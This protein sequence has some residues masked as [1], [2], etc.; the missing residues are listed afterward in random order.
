M[1]QLE[2]HSLSATL[3]QG[4]G[5]TASSLSLSWEIS[6]KNWNDWWGRSTYFGIKIE[7]V[8]KTTSGDK[9]YQIQNN[10]VPTIKKGDEYFLNPNNFYIQDGTNSKPTNIEGQGSKNDNDG[11][12]ICK[13]K[14]S[15]K[16]N[17]VNTSIYNILIE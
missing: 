14:A 5:T 11:I 13:Y 10:L 3:E 15:F 2:V 9:I 7:V 12:E 4:R 16:I 6:A 17:N 8:Y 1:A